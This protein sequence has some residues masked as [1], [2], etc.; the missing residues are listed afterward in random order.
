[1]NVKRKSKIWEL[2][3]EGKTIPEICNILDIKKGTV[4]YYL[5]GFRK[6]SYYIKDIPKETI[7][8]I[9]E[10]YQ[11]HKNLSKTYKNFNFTS[12]DTIRNILIQNKVYVGGK[13]NESPEE[14]SRRKSLHVINWKKRKKLKLIKYKGGKCQKCGYDKC[15]E[16]LEFHHLDPTKK[17]FNVSKH[18]FSFETMKKEVD[19]CIL[20]CANCHREIHYEL[21]NNIN[22]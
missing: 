8:N 17:D 2:R 6:K 9:I 21:K 15:E 11:E 22:F 3:K 16:A 1:M 5:K 13:R 4:G 19:K 12:K 10:F 20:V 7:K 18:S 14:V